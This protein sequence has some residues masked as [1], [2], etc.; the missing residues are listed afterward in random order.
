MKIKKGVNVVEYALIAVLCAVV[1]GMA[2]FN[3][4]GKDNKNILN[5]FKTSI[6]SP[7]EGLLE[8]GNVIKLEPMTD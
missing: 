4:N 6:S 8:N 1:I 3:I 5:I 7:N 2:I